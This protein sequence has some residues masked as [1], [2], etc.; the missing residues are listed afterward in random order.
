MGITAGKAEGRLGRRAPGLPA[1]S[2]R[3]QGALLL[4][5][6]GGAAFAGWVGAEDAVEEL[7][8]VAEVA[9]EV[10]GVLQI[11]GGEEFGDAGIFGDAV[12]EAGFG[13]PGGHGVFLDS[14]VGV[15]AGHAFF[16]EVLEE[17]AGKDEAVG[18]F[19][20]AEHAIG[21]NAHLADELGH[22]VE[23]VVDENGGIGENDALDA[24]V[25]DVA[26]VPEGDIFVGGEHV[27]A[28]QAG[29]ATDLFA[30]DGIAL[31]RHG[32]TAA[33]LVAEMFLGFAD[34]GALEVADFQ[35]DFFERGGDERED[36][37]ILRVAVALNYLRGNGRNVK[38]ELLADFLFD[39]R[40]EVRG[41]A[42][43]AGDFAERHV[44]R[45]L[46]GSA[47]YCADFRQTSWRSSGRR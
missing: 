20:V 38:S 7:V 28:D 3:Y 40:A 29:E 21:K 13:F 4:G 45:R 19:E 39:F 22:F 14:F 30:G 47:R 25:G 5:A 41:V 34:F 31:V 33:L 36:A 44:A 35:G 9:L 16:D 12:A 17:L 42:D 23:H 18:G 6:V 37:D 27:G 15:V 24:A 10:E 43:G 26:F 32:R 2:R 8:D 11:F 1:R 46:R